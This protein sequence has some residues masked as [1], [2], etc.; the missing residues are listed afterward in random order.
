MTITALDAHRDA[1]SAA[2]ALD[3]VTAAIEAAGVEYIYY[4]GVTSSG[5][6]IGK[7]V[8]SVHLRRNAE[9]GVQLHRT[10]VADLQSTRAGQ[11]LGGGVEAA[12]LTMVPDPDTT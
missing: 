9:K 7:V 5:R 6:L 3:A 8:P 10:V 4:Q 1:N 11:L 2:G 12:E